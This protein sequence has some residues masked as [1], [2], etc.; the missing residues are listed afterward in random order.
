FR[1]EWARYSPT[2]VLRLSAL[3]AAAAQGVVTVDFAEGAQRDKLH[4]ADSDVA[5]EWVTLVPRSG[6]RY[7]RAR[8]QLF[9]KHVRG[10][11]RA[12]ARRLPDPVQ[13]RLR[14][15]AGRPP[16]RRSAM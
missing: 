3:E 12:V 5:L 1:E 16:G 11:V 14:R 10:H 9:P 8:A 4:F 2:Y 15:L 7:L 13:Q 6:R